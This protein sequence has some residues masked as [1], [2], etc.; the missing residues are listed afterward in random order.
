M[1]VTYSLPMSV[2]RTLASLNPAMTFVYVSGTGT[3]SSGRGRSMWAR[4][5]G[6][7][8]NA[9]LQLPF[10]AAYMFRPGFIRPYARRGVEDEVAS[11]GI[12]SGGRLL[13]PVLRVLIPKYVTTT[14]CVGRAMINVARHGAPGRVLE[15]RDINTACGAG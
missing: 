5:K 10:K 6:E 3:D 12:C 7:T 13:D 1:R 9:L 14:E 15:S 8:E 2:A 11:A 4:V